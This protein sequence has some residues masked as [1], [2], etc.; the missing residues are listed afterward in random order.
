MQAKVP[1]VE[2]ARRPLDAL[3]LQAV[4]RPRAKALRV[5]RLG[6][7]IWMSWS[8]LALQ[9]Q[10]AALGW[11]GLGVGPGATVWAVGPL[12]ESFIIT[13]LAVQ[14]LGARLRV[15][16]PVTP[17]DAWGQARFV[18]AHGTAD[19]D[20]LL[21]QR[22]VADRDAT[23]AD[24]Q[25]LVVESSLGLEMIEGT[26]VLNWFALIEQA[27]SAGAAPPSH[28]ARVEATP[29][30]DPGSEAALIAGRNGHPR[31]CDTVLA[32]FETH[33]EAGVHWLLDDWLSSGAGLVLAEPDLDPGA[34]LQAT[35]PQWWLASTGVLTAFEAAARS[36]VPSSGLSGR[37]ARLAWTHGNSVML[38]MCC[39]R[40]RRVLGLAP[41][42]QA[43]CDGLI[44]PALA[45]WLRRLGV[46]V[47][48]LGP[49]RL[50]S[51]A[52][53]TALEARPQ[54]HHEQATARM[55]SALS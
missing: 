25:A 13:L 37:L 29:S 26:T 31:A 43:V 5:K 7:R 53:S 3:R 17:G 45:G 32:E 19:V 33:W 47:R 49:D 35:R 54:A 18:L 23:L 30:P 20:A 9:V 11:A 8:E 28:L 14:A 6:A 21:S 36:R 24:L 1:A 42:Q 46:V 27:T 48:Q 38:A 15:T 34:D 40:L 22:A 51:G 50:A 52:A 2:A 10:T 12:S 41:V 4:H 44:D 55:G 39:W 16:A